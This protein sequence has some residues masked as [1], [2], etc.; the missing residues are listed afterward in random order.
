MATSRERAIGDEAGVLESGRDLSIVA[1]RLINRRAPLTRATGHYG[2]AAPATRS[3]SATSRLSDS[4]EQIES[5]G[6]A[7]VN[8]ARNLKIATQSF[9][10]DASLVSSGGDLELQAQLTIDNAT[11]IRTTSWHGHWREWRG[12]CAAI[13]ITTSSASR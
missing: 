9:L 11:R 2:D 8:A 7:Q 12:C 10:N 1:D 13:A 3:I 5:S 4:T 6:P